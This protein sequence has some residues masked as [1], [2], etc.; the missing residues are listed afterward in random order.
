[1]GD[2][3]REGTSQQP[4]QCTSDPDVI[5]VASSRVEHDDEVGGA[6]V[7]GQGVEVLG[8]VERTGLL[9][10]LDDESTCRVGNSLLLQHPDR[11]HAEVA[12]VSV[13]ER[14]ATEQPRLTSDRLPRVQSL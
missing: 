10:G 5:V 7:V 8:E 9:A 12:A 11:G 13:V 4:A 14:P 3:H 1:M 6:E 2:L